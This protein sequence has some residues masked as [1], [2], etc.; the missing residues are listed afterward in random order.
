MAIDNTRRFAKAETSG[1]SNAKSSGTKSNGTTTTKTKKNTY[2]VQ[3]LDEPTKIDN[4]MTVEAMDEPTKDNSMTV[5]AKD[6]PVSSTYDNNTA[7]SYADASQYVGEVTKNNYGYT[8][9]DQYATAYAKVQSAIDSLHNIDTTR[10]DEVANQIRGRKAFSYDASKD[11]LFQNAMASAMKSGQL[12]MSNTMGQA[13]ALTGGYGSSY[14]TQASASAYADVINNT[15]NQ[16]PEYYKLNL[17][18]YNQQTQDLY[19]LYGLEKDL[20][21][22][23]K[24]DILVIHMLDIV[25]AEV[26][27]LLPA[28][29][30]IFLIFFL[31]RC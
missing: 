19:N 29:V 21:D 9:T 30:I 10:L 17:E 3:A 31:F 6:E 16:L 7:N 14:A 28:S 22:S 25:L 2:T 24:S 8:N 20:V 27:Y 5:E 13:A 26:A 23:Q 11:Q 12:A 4:S 15:L 1:K 18:A